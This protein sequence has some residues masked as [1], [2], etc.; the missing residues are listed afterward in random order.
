MNLVV[1]VVG[2]C[3]RE[4]FDRTAIIQRFE[5]TA[6]I[7]ASGQVEIFRP[8]PNFRGLAASCTRHETGGLDV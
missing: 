3:E 4:L 5:T 1:V 8:K 6:A 2:A 7:A